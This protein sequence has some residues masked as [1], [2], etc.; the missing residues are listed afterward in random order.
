MRP[1]FPAISLSAPAAILSVM[2][3]V[4]SCSA[5]VQAA[6]APRAPEPVTFNNGAIEL[7]GTLYLP[8][9]R[10]RHPAVVVFHAANGGTRDFHAYRHLVTALPAAGFAVLIYD[11]R[12]SGASGGDYNS[13][14]LEDLA[15]DGI[16]GIKLL[17]SRADIDP[18]RIGV[19]GMSQGGWLA[20]LAATLSPDVAFVASV[21]GPGVAPARQ[22]DYAATYALRESGYSA[23]VVKQAMQVRAAVDDYYRGRAVRSDAEQAVE[24]VR[25]EPWFSEIMLPNSGNLPDD[26]GRTKWYADMDYDPL[27]VLRHVRVP[28][29]FFFAEK[30]RWVPVEESIANIRRAMPANRGTIVRI[31]GADHFMETG[32]PDSGGPTSQ[33]YVSRLMEWLDEVREFPDHR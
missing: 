2:L 21:S 28:I 24:R 3:I 6:S 13:A 4:A 20:S 33:R 9:G 12:G 23:D 17:E 7:A 14:T 30:D 10:G 5:P 32:T 15:R 19:W 27:A 31:R 26:P 29:V 16:A 22:M 18:A 1:S 25:Q 8:A 11:R